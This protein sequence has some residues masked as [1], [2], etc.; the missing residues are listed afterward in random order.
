MKSWDCLFFFFRLDVIQITW[1][2]H[3]NCQVSTFEPTVVV[4][5]V[6]SWWQNLTEVVNKFLIKNK[7]YKIDIYYFIYLFHI[8]F[9]YSFY[10]DSTLFT[11]NI[12]ESFSTIITNLEMFQ[13][14]QLV[15][16]TMC[17]DDKYQERFCFVNLFCEWEVY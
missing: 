6:S 2:I 9:N 14:L 8:E 10:H 5:E 15:H 16:I 13:V 12:K 1:E 17:I 7:V 4:V 3:W 11:N